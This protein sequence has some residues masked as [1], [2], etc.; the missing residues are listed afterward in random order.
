[1]MICVYF[2]AMAIGCYFMFQKSG[3]DNVFKAIVPGYNVYNLFKM[4]WNES[5]FFPYYGSMFLGT[6]MFCAADKWSVK[7][8]GLIFVAICYLIRYFLGRF[9]LKTFD[10]KT[11][12]FALLFAIFP[13][14]TMLYISCDPT[15]Y[16]INNI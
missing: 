13:P 2:V 5:M 8:V 10:D 16:D 1:M 9:V 14:L 4:Y 7:I 3:E 12:G 6:C 15:L 11:P